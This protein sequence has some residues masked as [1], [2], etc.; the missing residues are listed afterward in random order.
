MCPLMPTISIWK[1]TNK[2][3]FSFILKKKK[4]KKKKKQEACCNNLNRY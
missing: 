1:Q 2:T 4:K 3:S